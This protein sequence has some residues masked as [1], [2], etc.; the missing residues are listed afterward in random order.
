MKT[1]N[2]DT[3]TRTPRFFEQHGSSSRST[4]RYYPSNQSG[5]EIS[6]GKRNMRSLKHTYDDLDVK[7]M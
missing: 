2:I 6:D 3:P 7:T 4:Y 1:P 5:D